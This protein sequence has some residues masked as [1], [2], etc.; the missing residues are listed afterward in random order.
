M[1]SLTHW[2]SDACTSTWGKPR[3]LLLSTG[4]PPAN[5][6]TALLMTL[7]N[8]DPGLTSWFCQELLNHDHRRIKSSSGSLLVVLFPMQNLP[9]FLLLLTYTV[10]IIRRV[11]LER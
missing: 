1:P 2:S 7:Q 4:L 9:Q 10:Q 11:I 6:H 3:Q 8:T 5:P